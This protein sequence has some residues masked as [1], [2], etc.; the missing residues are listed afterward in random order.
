DDD[1]SENGLFKTNNGLLNALTH[2]RRQIAAGDYR[3]LYA[4][5]EKYG[6]KDDE[7]PPPKPQSQ[8]KGEGI[9][10]NFIGRLGC[11]E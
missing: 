7:N 5:W 4:V 8:K 11:I 3:A 2:I 9:I 6:D 1:D 10:K